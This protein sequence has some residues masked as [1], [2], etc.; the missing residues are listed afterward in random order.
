MLFNPYDD[1]FQGT[2]VDIQS[3]SG[4]TA[5]TGSAFDT[6]GL[7][8]AMLHVRAAAATGSPTASTVT[9]ALLECATV[10]GSYTAALDN[11]GTAI[12]G[13]MTDNHTTGSDFFARIEGLGINRL[14]FLK[15]KVTPAF[16]SGTSPTSPVYAE[17][18]AASRNALP[19]G[20][21]VSNT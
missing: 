17:F 1:V 16:T 15:I 20:R 8:S 13:T 2:S 14:R 10:G 6:Q 9:V 3:L 7:D 12:G 18:I 11:T 5:V 21:A 19:V 4:T